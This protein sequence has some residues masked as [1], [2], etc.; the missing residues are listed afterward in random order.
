[1]KHFLLSLLFIFSISLV[2]SQYS[3]IK[4]YADQEKLQ[5]LQALGVAIDHGEYRKGVSLIA[6]FSAYEIELINNAGVEYDVLIKDVES[7]YASDRSSLKSIS[8]YVCEDDPEFL[9]EDPEN[10]TLGS[11]G[12]YL[13][14]QECLDNLDSMAELYPELISVRQPIDTFLTYEGRPLYWVQISDNP[15]SVEAGEAEVL[16]TSLH[17][18]REPATL[19]QNIYFMWYLLENYSS[20]SSIKELIDCT[21][22]YFVPV[23]NPDG[24]LWNES[25]NPNGGGMWRKNRRDNNGTLNNMGVDLNRN[26]GYEW[27]GLG[28]S[29]IYSSEIYRGDSAFSEPETQAI[30]YICENHDFKYALNYHSW[31]NLL[32]YPFGYDFDQLTEDNTLFE[33]VT[34]EMTRLN[35]Y[36]NI[37]S[38]NLYPHSGN[39]P[40]WMYETT[41]DKAKIMAMLPEIGDDFWPPSTSILGLCQE[42]LYPNLL[43]ARLAGVYA[44]LSYEG[45]DDLFDATVDLPFIAT[46]LGSEDG[47]VSIEFESLTAGMDVS[48]EESYSFTDPEIL[49]TLEINL[50][51]LLDETVLTIGQV[52]ALSV[53]LDNG[54]YS[55]ERTYYFTYQDQDPPV[56][57]LLVY[58]NSCEL[59]DEFTDN[60]GWDLTDEDAYS[61]IY[62]MTDSP[63]SD[64][65]TNSYAWIQ[66]EDTIDLTNAGE[67]SMTFW[68]KWGIEFGYDY[69]QVSASDDGGNS[70]IPLCG[71][72]TSS[73]SEYQDFEQPIYHGFQNEW[74]LETV[75]LSGFIGEEEILIA[76]KFESDFIY[77]YDGFYFDDISIYMV[78]DP[79][80]QVE[81]IEEVKF[82]VYPNPANDHINISKSNNELTYYEMLDIRGRKVLQGHFSEKDYQINVSK[83]D[84]GIYILH[85]YNTNEGRSS[86]KIELM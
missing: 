26:Y 4:L 57:T 15:D 83:L 19:S 34:D 74:I 13:T 81:S 7:Y 50:P 79:A 25:T 70:W 43:T 64:Y 65:E 33:A 30:K 29:A 84:R 28:S 16:Y 48:G 54:C 72:Y 42:N 40:D 69:A 24:Y 66:L 11:M 23:V 44:N 14:Y 31:G 49:E 77:T 21:A 86:K 67:A 56:N 8:T 62:S 10:F 27:G 6:E 46:R 17:H 22:L 80:A 35:N 12:G 61:P 20:D 47:D 68:A 73:G 52:L 3:R 51:V 1:M 85:L 18:A 45:S 76:F 53:I 38:S 59:L 39:A 75:D 5:E 41:N 82:S 55:E 71:N 32:L 63:N 60:I 58:D 36:S 37:I 78:E 9:L 2:Q